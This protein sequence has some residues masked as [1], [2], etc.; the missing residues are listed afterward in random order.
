MNRCDPRVRKRC[1]VFRIHPH[2]SIGPMTVLGVDGGR[3]GDGEH[4]NRGDGE[5]SHANLL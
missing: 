3:T 5:L 4:G 2:V 1:P